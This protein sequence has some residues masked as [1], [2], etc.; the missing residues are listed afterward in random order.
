M[1]GVRTNA[2]NAC[3]ASDSIG[4]GLIAFHW[5]HCIKTPPMLDNLGK[6]RHYA[7]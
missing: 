4:L 7:K 3:I 1:R 2:L 6:M 5:I